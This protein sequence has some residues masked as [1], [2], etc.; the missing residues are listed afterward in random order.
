[1]CT[2]HLRFVPTMDA[3]TEKRLKALDKEQIDLVPY[4][5]TWPGRYADLEKEV[6]RIIPRRLIQRIAHIGSTAVPGLSAKPIIDLQV[7]ISDADEVRDLVAPLMEE[8]GFEFLWRP[9]IGDEDPFY[10]WFI[11]RDADGRRCAHV[12][13]VR[14]GKA[15]MERILFRDYLS[16]FPEE[17]QRYAELK[18]DL[19]QRYPKNRAAYAAA[20]TSHVNEVLAKA[21][22]TKW[23]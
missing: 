3:R 5:P 17:A 10:S 22:A 6:K 16:A 19:A 14:P 9:S 18:R 15:S 1:M 4:D 11:L 23:R 12:H 13:V 2:R 7:E 8:A 21:R 20:K